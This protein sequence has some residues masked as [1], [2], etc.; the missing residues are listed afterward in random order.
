[1]PPRTA[2]LLTLAFLAGCD[3][4][5]ET[6]SPPSALFT[7]VVTDPSGDP[8]EG[9]DLFVGYPLPSSGASRTGAGGGVRIYPNPARERAVA[10]FFIQE[11]QDVALRLYD[12]DSTLVAT[13]SE[14]AYE[15]GQYQVS[16]DFTAVDGG[17]GGVYRVVLEGE[18]F[19]DET[20]VVHAAGP[21]ADTAAF[22]L[23][24][25]DAEG[26]VVVDD[27]TRFPSLYP[28]PPVI[29]VT[30]EEGSSLG[31]FTF[32]D[33]VELVLADPDTGEVDAEAFTLSDEENTASLTWNP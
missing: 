15:A 25:T 28:N 14:G 33:D 7:A 3:T 13:L 4:Q 16:V 2:V 24:T 30:D 29:E 22:Y 5:E 31:L 12:L 11:P 1:M 19:T 18:S 17:E 32:E 27:R 9:L 20:Y 23:G 6:P 8:V 21:A 26:R 10:S